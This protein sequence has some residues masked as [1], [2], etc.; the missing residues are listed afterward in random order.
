[1]TRHQEETHHQMICDGWRLHQFPYLDATIL[2]F[3]SFLTI[4][5]LLGNLQGCIY[6]FWTIQLCPV[7]IQYNISGF[8]N[9]LNYFPALSDFSIKTTDSNFLHS[10]MSCFLG[11]KQVS[12]TIC[13]AELPFPIPIQIPIPI[14]IEKH[15]NAQSINSVTFPL[16]VSFHVT[17]LPLVGKWGHYQHNRVSCPARPCAKIVYSRSM[18]QRSARNVTSHVKHTYPKLVSSR[19]R[20]F[21]FPYEYS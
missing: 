7:E 12:I 3:G 15:M 17:A 9:W 19:S 14:P 4:A 10:W 13:D 20:C 2:W 8:Y 21:S 1:M 5:N 6:P 16:P 18:W 11:L